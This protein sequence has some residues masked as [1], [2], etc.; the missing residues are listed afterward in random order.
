MHPSKTSA[1]FTS[2]ARRNIP[3]HVLSNF[4]SQQPAPDLT[5]ED[6]IMSCVIEAIARLIWRRQWYPEMR[7]DGSA[8]GPRISHDGIVP[9]GS[10]AVSDVVEARGELQTRGLRS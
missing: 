5:T 4:R 7:G 8:M 9:D 3:G 1:T 10:W 2:S 6:V